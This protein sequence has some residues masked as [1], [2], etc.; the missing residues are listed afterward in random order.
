VQG[1]PAAGEE[2]WT[3]AGSLGAGGSLSLTLGELFPG[4]ET[5]VAWLTVDGSFRLA[6]DIFYASP[7]LTRLGS[8]AGIGAE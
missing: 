5:E 4:H 6:G 2:G 8:Y 7:D 3:W 1:Y